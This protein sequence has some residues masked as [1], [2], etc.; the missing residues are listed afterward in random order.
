M[1]RKRDNTLIQACAAYRSETLAWWLHACAVNSVSW[2]DY[3]HKA[4]HYTSDEAAI[5]AAWSKHVR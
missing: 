5:E 1:S 2:K 4:I 3:W